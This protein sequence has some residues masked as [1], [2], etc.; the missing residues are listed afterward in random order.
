MTSIPFLTL[1]KHKPKVMKITKEVLALYDFSNQ[2]SSLKYRL[3]YDRDLFNEFKLLGIKI[4]DNMK[5]CPEF[6]K[7]FCWNYG[8]EKRIEK[9]YRSPRFSKYS[10]YQILDIIPTIWY[11][12]IGDTVK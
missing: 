11:S 2:A 8:Y 4:Q 5:M 12:R 9:L 3:K 10:L 7:V 6:S 1:R